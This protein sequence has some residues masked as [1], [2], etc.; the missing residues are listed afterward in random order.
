M[1]GMKEAEEVSLKKPHTLIP[2]AQCSRKGKADVGFPS[3]CCKCVLLS[4]VNEDA[5]LACGRA[6]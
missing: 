5:A 1:K 6:E 3:E 2:H 4:L